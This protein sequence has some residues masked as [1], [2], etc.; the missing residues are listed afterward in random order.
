M[1]EEEVAALV[2]DNGSGMCKA[3][4]I[5]QYTAEKKR[6]RTNT[7]QDTTKVFQQ[8]KGKNRFVDTFCCENPR[9]SVE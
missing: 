8:I 5:L 6:L 3:C 1:A 2:V 9:H 4:E 7:V